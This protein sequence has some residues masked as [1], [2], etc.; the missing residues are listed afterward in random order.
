M[1]SPRTSKRAEHPP[2]ARTRRP[3]ALERPMTEDPAPMPLRCP[4]ALLGAVRALA[5]A[6]L[7][8]GALVDFATT[9]RVDPALC[10]ALRRPDPDRPYGRRVLFTNPHLEVMVATWTPGQACAVHD[11]GEAFGVISVLEGEGEER[12]YA[13]RGGALAQIQAR[14]LVAGDRL[15]AGPGLLHA[16]GSTAPQGAPTLLTLHLYTPGIEDMIVYE[17]DVTY[18]I[19]GACGA[20]VPRDTPALIRAQRPGIWPRAALH[21]A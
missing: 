17:D 9:L 2:C 1:T 19:D 16:M 20:W 11:H 21:P 13:L 4:D 5:S 6:P 18:I 10:A 8:R 15:S 3:A 14:A 12:G 7:A